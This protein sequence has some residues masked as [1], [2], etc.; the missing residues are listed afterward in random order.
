MKRILMEDLGQVGDILE[1]SSDERRHLVNVRRISLDEEVELIDGHG[2]LALA[3]VVETSKKVL[4]LEVTARPQEDRES[5]PR[6]GMV[7][8]IP[9]QLSTF[10]GMLPGL[11]QLGVNHIYLVPTAWSGRIKKDPDRYLE[12]VQGIMLQSL[13]QCGRLVLP[14]VQVMRNWQALCDEVEPWQ[15]K[16]IY[17]PGGADEVPQDPEHAM[18]LEVPVDHTVSEIAA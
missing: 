12:R 7:L 11:V 2:G 18:L 10:D 15:T 8:A 14:K 5:Q 6:L 4:R 17:H 13:K 9:S 16:L 1:P 3:R